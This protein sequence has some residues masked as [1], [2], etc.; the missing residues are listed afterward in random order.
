M[1]QLLDIEPTDEIALERR[2]G[3]ACTA[4][5]RLANV[6]G[7]NVAFKVKTNSPDLYSVKPNQGILPPGK[8]Q[9]ITITLK[10]LPKDVT[11]LNHKFSI[12]QAKTTLSPGQDSLL[13]TFWADQSLPV[14]HN[15]LRT[16]LK[17]PETSPE[18]PRNPPTF[19][20][21]PRSE[22]LGRDSLPKYKELQLLQQS[23][24]LEF[25]K[26]QKKLYDLYAQ[27]RDIAALEALAAKPEKWTIG[28]SHVA[29]ALLC[30]VLVGL[31]V[32]NR[33]SE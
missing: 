33:S 13:T 18:Q 30:G 28:V 32:F 24:E 12:V 20:D 1:A 14:T 7:G 6:R 21:S 17:S 3:K 26:V 4:Y 2:P 9:K 25:A 11:E 8:T 29:I 19:P 22:P 23:Q 10:L 27:E 5:V 16:V 31:F 15:L